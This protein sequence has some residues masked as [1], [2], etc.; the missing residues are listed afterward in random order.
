MLPPR[1]Q[2]QALEDDIVA[3]VRAGDCSA[4]GALQPLRCAGART[5]AEPRLCMPQPGSTPRGL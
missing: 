4:D 5:R 1:E 3:Q 2:L